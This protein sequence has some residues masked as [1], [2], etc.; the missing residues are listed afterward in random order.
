M[1]TYIDTLDQHTKDYIY[2]MANRSLYND[3]MNELNNKYEFFKEELDNKYSIMRFKNINMLITHQYDYNIYP[4]S[5]EHFVIPIYLM[6]KNMT[7]PLAEEIYSLRYEIYSSIRHFNKYEYHINKLFDRK[8]LEFYH[9]NLNEWVYGN[10]ISLCQF[11]SM[12]LQ[13]GVNPKLINKIFQANGLNFGMK[14]IYING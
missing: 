2:Q 13:N 14:E 8:Q 3:V 10:S 1:V 6:K 9:G 7:F 4:Q 5:F 12:F 11:Y